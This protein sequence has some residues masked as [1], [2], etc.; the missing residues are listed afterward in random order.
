MDQ[1]A[2][3][4]D[5]RVFGGGVGAQR[6]AERADIITADTIKVLVEGL[7]VPSGGAALCQPPEVIHVAFSAPAGER[8]GE[9]VCGCSGDTAGDA[10]ELTLICGWSAVGNKDK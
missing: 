7:L 10:S 8:E 2:G 1:S 6:A 4:I 3:R 9:I 5:S